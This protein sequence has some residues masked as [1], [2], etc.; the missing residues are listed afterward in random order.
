M[1]FVCD[2]ALGPQEIFADRC[3]AHPIVTS[4]G[5]QQP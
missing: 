2:I 3:A 5:L 4:Y 1:V